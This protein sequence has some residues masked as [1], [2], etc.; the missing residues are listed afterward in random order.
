[1]L[2][3]PPPS[4][5]TSD[6]GRHY[7]SPSF[8]ITFIPSPSTLPDHYIILLRCCSSRHFSVRVVCCCVSVCGLP[9]SFYSP[10][11]I[12]ISRPHCFISL[13]ATC[14]FRCG[15]SPVH[16]DLSCSLSPTRQISN[17]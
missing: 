1:A 10:S 13:R 7:R 11:I 5:P 6:H 2:T 4:S 15:G 12:P 14:C 3:L 17:S 8:I 9:A 16:L